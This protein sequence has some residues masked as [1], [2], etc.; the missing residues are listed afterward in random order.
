MKKL[1]FIGLLLSFQ[2]AWGQT[3]VIVGEICPGCAV[4]VKGRHLQPSDHK[5]GCWWLA[6]QQQA[7]SSSEDSGS[8]WGKEPY[9]DSGTFESVEGKPLTNDEY[10]ELLIRT[11]CDYCGA[12]FSNQH[13]GDCL[14]GKTYNMWQKTMRSGKEGDATRLRDNIVTLMLSTESGRNKLHAM[15]GE[16]IPLTAEESS[17]ST[18]LKDYTPE[19]EKPA[20]VTVG[21]PLLSCPQAQTAP[22]FSGINEQSV[23][24]EK[25]QT[26]A[27]KHEWGE[28]G[29]DQY[30]NSIKYDI[31]RRTHVDGGPVILGKRNKDGSKEWY[32]FHGNNQGKYGGSEVYDNRHG[33]SPKDVRFEG[34]G[35]F[36]VEEYEDGHKV[37]TDAATNK[38]ITSGNVGI[39]PMMKNGRF[40]LL[41][42]QESTNYKTAQAL[43][44]GPGNMLL[45]DEI[46]LMDDAIVT[47]RNRGDEDGQYCQLLNWD[48]QELSID[49]DKYFEAIYCFQSNRGS[50]FVIKLEEGKYALVGRGFRRVGGIYSSANEALLAWSKQ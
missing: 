30:Y 15:R 11:H 32:V 45:G 41:K 18:K 36:V 37:Y 29:E 19:P 7:Q 31:E 8:S 16:A 26:A 25:L 21:E 5:A 1:V 49:G 43:Y 40:L 4:V 2:L 14:I 22:K 39:A 9:S 48:W 38:I 13:K 20:A 6:Q 47:R 33:G 24:Y 44:D 46:V 10:Y 27:G 17:P 28:V 12:E 34:E 35:Q 42:H 50:Y 23:V 3:A